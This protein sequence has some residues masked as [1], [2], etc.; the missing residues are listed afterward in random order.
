MQSGVTSSER[1]DLG[2]PCCS[3]QKVW[4]QFPDRLCCQPN[5]LCIYPAIW[6]TNCSCGRTGLSICFPPGKCL[7]LERVLYPLPSP[8]LPSPLK[9]YSCSMSPASPEF[10]IQLHCPFCL[11]LRWSFSWIRG[12]RNKCD[13]C[14]GCSVVL[15]SWSSTHFWY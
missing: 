2:S 6:K 1:H 12:G 13:V 10:W 3:E 11:F 5:C 9:R 15:D 14:L 7:M 4:V 8:Q